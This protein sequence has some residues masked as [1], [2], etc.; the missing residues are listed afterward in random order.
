MRRAAS[1]ANRNNVSRDNDTGDAR[2]SVGEESGELVK[3]IEAGAERRCDATRLFLDRDNALAWRA[4]ENTRTLSI[5]F[6]CS[7]GRV[8][9]G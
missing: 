1:R 6:V 2:Q 9:T 7:A 5:A 8:Y 4:I 3:I